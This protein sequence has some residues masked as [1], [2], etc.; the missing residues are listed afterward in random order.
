[1]AAVAEV[2]LFVRTGCLFVCIVRLVT[3]VCLF[4]WGEGTCCEL[5]VHLMCVLT[6][7][8]DTAEEVVVVAAAT[9]VEVRAC[10]QC[11]LCLTCGRSWS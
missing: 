1:M 9:A 5:S 6:T 11:C 2:W 10:D 3:C 4:V 8:Q 7:F